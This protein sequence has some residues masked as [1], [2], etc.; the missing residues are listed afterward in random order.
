MEKAK[1][2]LMEPF[3]NGRKR[4]TEFPCKH[5]GKTSEELKVKER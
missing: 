5:G 2:Y 3:V 1:L 4:I